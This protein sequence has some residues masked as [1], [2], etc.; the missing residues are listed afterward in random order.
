ML[1]RLGLDH[2]ATETVTKA[3]GLLRDAV[4]S[5]SR[6]LVLLLDESLVKDSAGE[7]ATMLR[8]DDAL[9]AARIV[10]LAQ[11]PANSA[12]AEK[13]LP[14]AAV[15]RK[16]LVRPELLLTA[17]RQKTP[18]PEPQASDS[19]PPLFPS[20]AK[21]SDVEGP[22]VLVVDDDEISR[23]VASQLLARLG[24]VIERATGGAEAVARARAPRR[25][26]SF[27]WT[28][29][30]RESTA[31]RQRRSFLPRTGPRRRPSWR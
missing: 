30:C 21:P 12:L 28:A 7:L 15:V 1:T 16:P 4:A 14:L 24:C 29:R 26:T 27:L 23:S 11:N 18:V 20:E 3:T 10:L 8:H 31:S 6:E 19:R 17:V 9:R 2:D 22:R 13:F 25:L 5:G